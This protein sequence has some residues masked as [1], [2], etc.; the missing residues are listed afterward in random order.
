M[1]KAFMCFFEQEAGNSVQDSFIHIAS[2]ISLDKA[3]SFIPLLLFST[4]V[5]F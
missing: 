3:N 1:R 2:C 4:F 5:T